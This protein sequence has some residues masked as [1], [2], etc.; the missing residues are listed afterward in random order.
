MGWV[1][2]TLVYANRPLLLS[3]LN[4]S[5][6]TTEVHFSGCQK[7]VRPLSRVFVE[8]I[9]PPPAPPAPGP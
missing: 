2:V 9:D 8:M 7:N 3:R 5:L 1:A 6:Y 4:D